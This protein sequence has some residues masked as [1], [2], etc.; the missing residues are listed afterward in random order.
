[1]RFHARRMGTREVRVGSTARWSAAAKTGIVRMQYLH[2]AR[3]P[4]RERGRAA[5]RRQASWARAS[6][7]RTSRQPRGVVNADLRNEMPHLVAM[8]LCKLL[9]CF[10]CTC[11]VL[12]SI[13]RSH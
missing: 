2:S 5:A 3:S 11:N 10:S 9:S 13:N 6:M 12:I 8:A 7:W 4:R 1:M